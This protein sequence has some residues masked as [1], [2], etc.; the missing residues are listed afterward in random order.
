M[1]SILCTDSVVSVVLV[2]HLLGPGISYL[3]RRRCCHLNEE[4][5]SARIP[6]VL[7]YHK[8]LCPSSYRDFHPWVK[9]SDC[10]AEH[11]SFLLVSKISNVGITSWCL[12]NP[13]EKFVPLYVY[14]LWT[15]MPFCSE[16]SIAT[17]NTLVRLHNHE[18]S[19]VL[20]V[21]CNYLPVFTS[22]YTRRFESV[23]ST[24]L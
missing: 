2:L 17:E 8:S 5:I 24:I 15:F 11:W 12:C 13:R 10:G 23:I 22:T 3:V 16:W 14:P 18:S 1:T 6:A 20:R 7:F 21:F 4:I 19:A 9:R